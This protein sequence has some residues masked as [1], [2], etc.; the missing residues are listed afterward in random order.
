MKKNHWKEHFKTQFINKSPTSLTSCHCFVSKALPVRV[1]GQRGR[2]GLPL[3]V[4]IG[5]LNRSLRQLRKKQVASL[6]LTAKAPENG[7]L[8]YKPF[9]LGFG[10]FS[11]AIAVSFREGKNLINNLRLYEPFWLFSPDF[12]IFLL[13][14]FKRAEVAYRVR[15]PELR[16]WF[17]FKLMDTSTQLI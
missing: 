13:E 10:L 6:K 1:A 2:G 8:E 9:L 15:G 4:P 17:F 14:I 7:W 16:G 5:D 12:R 3:G 11:G